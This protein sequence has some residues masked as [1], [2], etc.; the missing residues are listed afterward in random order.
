MVFVGQEHG[1]LINID[2]HEEIICG[3]A[4]AFH[5]FDV[6]LWGKSTQYKQVSMIFVGQVLDKTIGS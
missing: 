2:H 5:V 6:Y 4:C 3:R 1:V